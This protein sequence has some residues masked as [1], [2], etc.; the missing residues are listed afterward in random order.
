MFTRRLGGRGLALAAV[1]AVVAAGAVQTTARADSALPV[2]TALGTDPA[3]AGGAPG[4]SCGSDEPYGSIGLGAVRFVATATTTDGSL[5]GTEFAVTPSDGTS[6]YD[7]TGGNQISGTQAQLTLPSEDFTDGVTYTWQARAVG[8]G[9]A[10][11]DWSAPCHFVADHTPPAAP[12]LTSTDFPSETSGLPGPY[13][14][15]TGTVHVTVTGPGSSDAVT[16]TY[17]TDQGTVPDDSGSAVP[18]AADGTADITITPTSWGPHSLTVQTLDRV[19]NPSQE[20]RYDF[21]VATDPKP[22]GHGDVNGD[23]TADLIAAG[24][25]GRLRTLI[26]NGDGTLRPAV[27]HQD[28]S[29]DFTGLITLNGD[30]N[31]DGYQDLLGITPNHVLEEAVNNGLGDLGRTTV[32]VTRQGSDWSAATQLVQPGAADGTSWGGLMSVEN[33]HLLQ[34]PSHN[35]FIFGDPTDLGAGY[36]D[37]TLLTPG[38]LTGDGVP[39]LLVRDDSTGS[40]RIAPMT[41]DGTVV[42]ESGWTKVGKGFGKAAYPLL[43]VVGDAN[44]DGFPDMYGVTADGT[45]NFVPGKAGGHFGKAKPVSGTGLDWSTITGLA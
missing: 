25:D 42:P 30:G 36:A 24:A 10:V 7:Y 11:S 13:A 32:G 16:A 6:G 4:D 15:T 44:G 45:L 19:G 22:D 27:T 40:L 14:R 33:G 41:A 17:T 20:I 23:G 3:P 8:S 34:W 12:V 18:I 39:D 9:G 1:C 21:I 37:L 26:G 35:G 31:N 5:V 29:A 38:D 28:S 2:P 43:T